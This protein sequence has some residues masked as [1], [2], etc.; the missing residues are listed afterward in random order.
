MTILSKK[1]KKQ[2]HK[3]KTRMQICD[4]FEN[5][6]VKK[7]RANKAPKGQ[8]QSVNKNER[9]NKAKQRRKK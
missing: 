7:L 5:A 6:F 3:K 2:T 1:K 4:S 8:K 9:E